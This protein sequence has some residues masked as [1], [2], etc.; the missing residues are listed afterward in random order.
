MNNHYHLLLSPLVENGISLFMQKLNMGYTKYFNEKYKRSG[1]LWQGKYKKILIQREAH[2]LYIPYYIHLN[3]LDYTHPEWREGKVTT[4]QGALDALSK[5]RWS[6][7][8]DYS[9]TK[10]FPS[11]TERGFLQDILGETKRYQKEIQNIITTADL[12][13]GSN[14]IE[15]KN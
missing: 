1:A 15:F 12:A 7:H 5:Y 4:I 10:N 9:G 14:Y 8:L 11:L 6:S 2:F 13:Q 3:P